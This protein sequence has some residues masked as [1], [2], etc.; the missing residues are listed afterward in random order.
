MFKEILAFARS[1]FFGWRSHFFLWYYKNEYAIKG[2]S[3]DSI[4]DIDIYIFKSKATKLQ[5]VHRGKLKTIRTNTYVQ[6][7]KYTEWQLNRQ[8]CKN[9]NLYI[10][11]LS[12]MYF[13]KILLWP[14]D[15]CYYLLFIK[16]W[17]FLYERSRFSVMVFWDFKYNRGRFCWW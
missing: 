17:D 14:K 15:K 12:P 4:I 7:E 10:Y 3:S 2:A 16:S 9:K 6:S 13:Y 5:N 8:I 11:I 1:W